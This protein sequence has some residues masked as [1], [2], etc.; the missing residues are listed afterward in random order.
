MIKMSVAITAY[1]MGG[2][3]HK[4]LEYALDS[5]YRQTF[6]DFEVVVSDQSKDFL[7]AETCY[8]W[9]EKLNIVYCREEKNRGYF[10]ANE[11]WAIKHSAGEIIKFLDADDFLY[12]ENSLEKTI[13]AF[14]PDINWL[15]TDYVH[16]YD[17]VSFIN[18]HAPTMN[19][20]I[21]V[22]NTIGTPSCISV[23]NDNIPLFDEK[24]R[25]AGDCEWYR[26][27]YNKWGVFKT[28]NEITAV[29]LLWPGQNENTI[30]AS[31]ELQAKENSY[32][33]RKHEGGSW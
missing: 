19:N 21:H 32:I 1:E 25:W 11:N 31:E 9:K 10:T 14:T 30:G 4:I 3:G 18:R 17:R 22:I 6:K 27:L 15:A 26:Q 2:S 7:V 8:N 5:L 20:R 23:R 28:L 16:S 24:L 12:D 33:I 13:I 29:H